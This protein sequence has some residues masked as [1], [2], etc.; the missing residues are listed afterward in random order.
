M[1]KSQTRLLVS[2]QQE[3]AELEQLLEGARLGRGGFVRILGEPGVGK[4][5]LADA[6]ADRAL[7][8]GLRAV[9]VKA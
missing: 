3:L 7:D 4:S 1:Q 2:R 9:W 6:L 8:R 5:R